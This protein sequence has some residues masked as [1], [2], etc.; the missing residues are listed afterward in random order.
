ML[1]E[2]ERKDLREDDARFEAWEAARDEAIEAQH[3][4]HVDAGENHWVTCPLCDDEDPE[5]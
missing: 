1:T 2:Q 3:D 5:G 4:A